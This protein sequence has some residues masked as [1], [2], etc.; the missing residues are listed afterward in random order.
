[1]K[2]DPSFI[3]A[4]AGTVLSAAWIMIFAKGYRKGYRHS[5]SGVTS[6]EITW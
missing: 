3:M 2:T 5:L 4:A 1:M 6:G